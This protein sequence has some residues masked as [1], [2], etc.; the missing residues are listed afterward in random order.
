[1]NTKNEANVKIPKFVFEAM[2]RAIE[3]STGYNQQRI[4][5]DWVQAK[6]HCLYLHDRFEDYQSRKGTIYEQDYLK[7][8]MT[9]KKEV[10]SYWKPQMKECERKIKNKEADEHE[11]PF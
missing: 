9:K 5:Y 6:K 2:E 10:D 11:S 4:L 3:Y 7:E 1:M 8:Y